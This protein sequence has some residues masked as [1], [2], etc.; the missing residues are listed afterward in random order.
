MKIL[1]NNTKTNKHTKLF[2]W[3]DFGTHTRETY[4][5]DQMEKNTNSKVNRKQTIN[6]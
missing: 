2:C 6:A 1:Q 5:R 3:N 4:R